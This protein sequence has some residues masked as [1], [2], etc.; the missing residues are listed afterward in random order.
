M[1]LMQGERKKNVNVILSQ[2]TD[3]AF[4]E[5]AQIRSWWTQLEALNVPYRCYLFNY[6]D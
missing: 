5:A 4:V 2:S 3:R 6:F 1:T